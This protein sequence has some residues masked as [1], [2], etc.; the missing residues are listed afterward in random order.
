VRDQ[1][2]ATTLNVF[3]QIPN[4]GQGQK[5]PGGDQFVKLLAWGAWLAFGLCVLGVIVAGATMAIQHRQ[6]QGG[7]HAARLG[8]VA[9]GCVVVGSASALVGALV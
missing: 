6:G 4:P 1:L 5:P 3:A 7:E 9:A 8:W 2:V